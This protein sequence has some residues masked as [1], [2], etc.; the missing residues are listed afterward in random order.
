M[1]AETFGDVPELAAGEVDPLSPEHVVTLV[2]FLA[3]PAAESVN[4]QVF[5]VYGPSVALVAAPV[6]EQTF[7]ASGDAWAQGDL[8]A[9]LAGYFADRDPD[10]M[11]SSVGLLD[12]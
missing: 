2:R 3:S 9:A 6:L 5:V 1:T 4:G 7:S 8:S 12:N 10:R 11:F